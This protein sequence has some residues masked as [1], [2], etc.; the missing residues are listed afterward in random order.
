MY[1]PKKTNINVH[2][3]FHPG[4]GKNREKIENAEAAHA[5]RLAEAAQRKTTLEKEKMQSQ[6]DALKASASIVGSSGKLTKRLALFVDD[7]EA[8]LQAAAGT[9]STA[10]ASEPQGAAAAKTGTVSK[11]EAA[12]IRKALDDERKARDDPLAVMKAREAAIAAARAR[13][14]QSD[15]AHGTA[16]PPQGG[17]AAAATRR[18]AIRAGFGASWARAARQGLRLRQ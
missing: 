12:S 10:A 9:A 13:Q 6:Y 4:A 17:T 18:E 3:V 11:E 16:S 2:K 8:A 14:H 7:S 15:G 5:T 1:G